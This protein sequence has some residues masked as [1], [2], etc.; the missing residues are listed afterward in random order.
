MKNNFK[1]FA[2]EKKELTDRINK[3]NFKIP[4]NCFYKLKPIDINSNSWFSIEKTPIDPINIKFK[5]NNS[6][7]KII[8]CKKITILPNEKQTI[9]LIDWFES[10]RKM[11]NE[12][13]TVIKKL[14][15]ENNKNMFNFRYIRT[16]K[17]KELKT[18]LIE[19]T[20]INSHILDGAI[21]LACAS[22]KSAKSNL[23]NGNI[24]QFTIRPIKQNKKSKI[25]DL[26]KCYFYTD[27]FC[28]R[29]LGKMKTVDNFDFT[30]INSD[31]KLHYNSLKNRFTLLVPTE[32]SCSKPYNNSSF[33][34]ID[35]GIK[36]FLTGISNKNIYKIGDNLTTT[37]K[38]NL[39]KIDKLASINNKKSRKQIE[40]IKMKNYNKITDLH[41]KSI[42][43][44]LK[45]EEIN[46]IL[47]GNWS[48]K[49]ISSNERK[50]DKMNKRLANSLRFYEFIQKLKYKCIQYN[51]NLKLVNESY[52]SK[53]CSFCSSL[54]EINKN[55]T[56]NCSCKMNLNRDINGSI[57]ILLKCLK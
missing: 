56:L 16:Y 43:Y 26:E 7:D 40:S 57:N 46:S 11:Y 50:L 41:W 8:N 17:M 10:Y 45:I 22:F 12:T 42:N 55:R 4:F 34:S 48:T 33:I 51:S 30:T 44:L 47:I 21:K 20:N 52:T 15:F 54:S 49:D 9:I 35:P 28:K 24:K 25:M 38:N 2:S 13:L 53:V 1:N 3:Y 6:N 31:C 5:N 18:K 19:G 23:K 14:I 39:T 27:G 32:I 36:T 29:V 37:I